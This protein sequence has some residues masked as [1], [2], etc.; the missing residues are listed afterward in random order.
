MRQEFFEKGGV[1]LMKI[2]RILNTI[3]IFLFSLSE[4]FS[5]H[6]SLKSA[7]MID[8]VAQMI[9]TLVICVGAQMLLLNFL[10]ALGVLQNFNPLPF[11]SLRIGLSADEFEEVAEE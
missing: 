8:G 2:V 11:I 1:A 5:L 3:V 4:G 10:Y 6:S 7:T 9:G